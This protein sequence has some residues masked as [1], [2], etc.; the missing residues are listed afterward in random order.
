MRLRRTVFFLAAWILACTSSSSDETGAQLGD[1]ATASLSCDVDP[2]GVAVQYSCDS[3][4]TSGQ[5]V[6]YL[7]GFDT[8]TMD[9]TCG[10][11]GG[12]ATLEVSCDVEAALG[13]CCSV[14]NGQWYVTHFAD[15]PD[16]PLTAS[17]LQMNCESA[18]DT[19]YP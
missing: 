18:G 16:A 5:C 14:S 15:V 6:D 1:T 7:E 12:T 13:R 9:V 11:L 3:T 2:D 8:S 17:E 19:W 10:A 4:S